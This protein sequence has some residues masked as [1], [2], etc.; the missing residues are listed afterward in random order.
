MKNIKKLNLFFLV[1]IG[2]ILDYYDFLL[3]AHLGFI[4]TPFFISNLNAKE[5]HLF[6]LLLFA[7]PFIL[8]PIG[9]YFFGRIADNMGALQVLS[10]TLSYSS[11][12]T[13]ALACLPSYADIGILSSILF[14]ALR[15]VQGISLGGEYTTA[16]T[17]LMQEYK[18]RKGLISGILCA[19]GTIGSLIAF[20][21]A[22]LYSQNYLHEQFWRL[23]F[24]LGGIGAYA[25]MLL[26][27][28]FIQPNTNHLKHNPET[29]QITTINPFY[30]T[31]LIG[32]LVSILCWL[33]MV[34]TN[35]YLTKI[36]HFSIKTGLLATFIAL[37]SY[38]ILNILCGFLADYYSAIRI[39]KIG[40]LL[41]LP[42]GIGGYICIK[43]GLL[44][45]QIL[46]I[47]A[48]SIFGAPIHVVMNHL[49][50]TKN[51]SRNLNTSFMAGT[52]FGGLTPFISGYFSDNYQFHDLPIIILI[53]ITIL[54]FKS[55][56]HL[57]NDNGPVKK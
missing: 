33:P 35:F 40:S 49:F 34:Y 45:G 14:I 11:F 51:K 22:W 20:I 7:L 48:A 13:F 9:G 15:S 38:I 46:L 53:I 41:A 52:A 42:L 10:K 24:L 8:R 25:S 54:V 44:I 23:A 4:I 6:S 5:H 47:S 37:I 31:F 32:A 26:R 50:G 21:I 43:H 18:N 56:V 29:N 2:N 30:I 16:G 3:F 12:A 27:R 55:L 57:Q 28:K 39:M 19:S 36:L 17:F 1:I